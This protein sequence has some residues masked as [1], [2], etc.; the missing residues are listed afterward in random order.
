VSFWRTLPVRLVI[1]AAIIVI[2]PFIALLLLIT[3]PI[4][5]PV[6]N[7]TACIST[8]DDVAQVAVVFAMPST[9]LLWW[10]DAAGRVPMGTIP[11]VIF[12]TPVFILLVMDWI[13]YGRL[14]H[15]TSPGGA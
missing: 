10:S 2:V 6:F 3:L 11:V 1:V 14:L 8:V 5:A 12:V 9:A 4:S 13:C 15:P 7:P